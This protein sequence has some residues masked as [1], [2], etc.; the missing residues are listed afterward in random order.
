[1]YCMHESLFRPAKLDFHAEPYPS[2]KDIFLSDIGPTHMTFE[3]SP[4]IFNCPSLQYIITSDSNCGTCPNATINATATCTN[5]TIN[6]HTCNLFVQT[7]V[8]GSIIGE[9][10]KPLKVK[11]QG[12]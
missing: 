4:L 5:M 12:M 9:K 10:S 1:M 8:C 3:W 2:P 6:G 7:E 11:L